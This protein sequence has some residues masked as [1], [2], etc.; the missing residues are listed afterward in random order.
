MSDSR[1]G[2]MYVRKKLIIFVESNDKRCGY[3]GIIA[4]VNASYELAQIF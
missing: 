2:C 1:V 3:I 4:L